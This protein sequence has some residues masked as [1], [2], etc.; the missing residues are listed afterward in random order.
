M[1]GLDRLPAALDRDL[2]PT[3][4]EQIEASQER[5][6]QAKDA[7]EKRRCLARI[8]A[9][10]QAVGAKRGNMF[11]GDKK[12]NDSLDPAAYNRQAEEAGFLL[13]HLPEEALD[14]MCEK[15]L[16]GHGGEMLEL[17][18]RELGR[19]RE[20][21][22]YRRQLEEMKKNYRDPEGP[23]MDVATAMVLCQL[24]PGMGDR[25]VDWVKVEK[26]AEILRKTDGYAAFAADP[27]TAE[28]L[29]EGNAGELALSFSAHDK[30]AA[31]EKERRNDAPQ[32]AKAAEGPAAGP[33][34]A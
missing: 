26:T 15:A 8:I 9:A 28:L 6:K 29:R 30:R 13:P 3:A 2:C 1:K 4:K 5:L 32:A 22:T 21:N 33:A 20:E 23:R 14:R 16:S 10:R 7:E 12:L 17:Y 27:R 11:G 24:T 25:N 31:E 19:E 18:R 34:G